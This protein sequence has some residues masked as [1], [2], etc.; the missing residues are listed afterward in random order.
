[1]L[2]ELTLKTRYRSGEDNLLNDFYIPTLSL[3][4]VYHRSVGYFTSNSL[5]IAAKGVAALIK[6]GGK[7][8]LIA[9]PSLTEEDVEAINLGHSKVEDKVLQNISN[10]FL[11]NEDNYTKYRLSVLSELIRENRLEIKIAIKINNAGKYVHGIYHEKLGVIKDAFGNY[12]SFEGSANETTGGIVANFER[13]PVHTSWK[14]PEGRAEEI[15]HDFRSLWGNATVGLEVIPF[16]DITSDLLK[17]YRRRHPPKLADDYELIPSQNNE[18]VNSTEDNFVPPPEISLRPYQLKI[19]NN[20][21]EHKNKGI[22]SLATGTGKT[23]SAI[24]TA[25]RLRKEGK[26]AGLLILCPLKNL[27]EQWDDELKKFGLKPLLA[28]M[29]RDSWE[30]PLHEELFFGRDHTHPELLTVVTT[31]STFASDTFQRYLKQFPED[32]MLIA[33]EAHHLGSENRFSTLPE[34]GFKNKLA[35]SATPERHNDSEGT[36]E[37]INYFGNILD[38]RKSVGEAIQD[39]FLCPYYYHPI[40]V[41][42]KENERIVEDKYHSRMSE[43]LASGERF[44]KSKLLEQLIIKI[45]KSVPLHNGKINALKELLN[46]KDFYKTLVY[47]GVGSIDASTITDFDKDRMKIVDIVMDIIGNTFS[48]PVDKYTAE[49]KFN[50]RKRIIS[51]LEDD[52]IRCLIAMNC[53]DEGVDIPCVQNAIILSSSNNPRQFI[54]R[55]GRVLRKHEGKPHACI[56]DMITLPS[57]SSNLEDLEIELLK[58]ESLRYM[59]FAKDAINHLECERLLWEYKKKLGQLAI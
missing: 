50:D 14:D 8:K 7:M 15:D 51:Q 29:T 19:I 34:N 35:L 39:G 44:G 42:L 27:V 28:Y 56:Y 26:L 59:D 36:E 13:L 41:E 12:V 22:Y 54:Q 32:S 23:I 6:N 58:Y 37:L 24:S 49:T 57:S 46:T 17:Q 21:F 10:H 18:V 43:L 30:G 16:T 2:S 33:D 25:C 3:A 52:T 9:S 20:W 48:I 31:F 4:F 55:R 47:C 45:N 38:P 1:M 40:F 5:A 53:L 11:C